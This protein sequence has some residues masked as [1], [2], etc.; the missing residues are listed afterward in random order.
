MA[1]IT[2][3]ENI[4]ILEDRVAE[5]RAQ[6]SQHSSYK[7]LEAQGRDSAR[8]EFTDPAKLKDELREVQAELQTAYMMV[9]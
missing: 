2:P 5:I 1:K 4:T 3:A 8:T 7:A 9:R 6:L